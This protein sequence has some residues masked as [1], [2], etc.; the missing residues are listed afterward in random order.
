MKR[1]LIFAAIGPALGGFLLLG[2]MTWLSGYWTT[3]SYAE[4][5]QFLLIL[6]TTLQYSYLFALL[7]SLAIAAIDDIL[8]HYPQ[9]HWPMRMLLCS[10]IA[11]AATAFMYGGRG[12]DCRFQA[13]RALRPGRLRPD[14]AE[15][16]ALPPPGAEGDHGAG[17]RGATVSDGNPLLTRHARA[18]RG[19]PRLEGT[20]ARS[21][22]WMAGTSPAM[23]SGDSLVATAVDIVLPCDPP[24]RSRRVPTLDPLDLA[25][26]R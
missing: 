12:A 23:N 17:V 3:T 5:R 19:H 22:T 14:A 25:H 24:P 20:S 13:I 10:S 4:V 16:L 7:P 11:F 1:Y 8:S 2:A 18:C 21:K 9:L 26:L 15:L 6:F